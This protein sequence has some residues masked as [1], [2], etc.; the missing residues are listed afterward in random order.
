[1]IAAL[2]QGDQHKLRQVRHWHEILGTEMAYWKPMFETA[3]CHQFN[4][5]FERSKYIRVSTRACTFQK[6]T[7]IAAL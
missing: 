7:M 4:E 2:E 6:T 5:F 3:P 1:M